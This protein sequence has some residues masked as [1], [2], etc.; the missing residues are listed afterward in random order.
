[1]PAEPGLDEGDVTYLFRE[2]DVIR[3]GLPPL[4]TWMVV[5]VMRVDADGQMRTTSPPNVGVSGRVLDGNNSLFVFSDSG[6]LFAGAPSLFTGLGAIS[7]LGTRI[8]TSGD[9][10]F[11]DAVISMDAAIEDA[12]DGSTKYYAANDAL[13]TLLVPAIYSIDYVLTRYNTSPGGLIATG[14]QQVLIQSGAI[15]PIVLPSVPRSQPRQ[16]PPKLSDARL[17]VPESEGDS[18]KIEL[19]GEDFTIEN[20]YAALNGFNVSNLGSKVE[21][22]YVTIEIGARDTFKADGTRLVLGG[23]DI[24]IPGEDL[25]LDGEV[26]SFEIPAGAQ[27]AG[28]LITVTRPMELPVDNEFERQEIVSNPVQLLG[29]QR[30]AMVASGADGAVL[31]YDICATVTDGQLGLQCTV[32]EPDSETRLNPFTRAAITIVDGTSSQRYSPRKTAAAPDG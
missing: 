28:G 30:Y 25:T 9:A 10:Q 1:M 5:D 11:G 27:I 12:T 32:P 23:K 8:S 26:L 16:D 21:D 3:E 19:R 17:V 20:P 24:T 4:S 29:D 18:L 13:G 6:V 22:L 15:P 7:D 2:V 14:N 31:I